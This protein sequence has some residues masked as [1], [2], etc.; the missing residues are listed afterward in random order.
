MTTQELI[1]AVQNGLKFSQMDE[2]DSESFAGAPEGALIAYSDIAVYILKG[3][4]LSVV[5]ED[6]ETQ[7]TL[8]TKFEFVIE[9]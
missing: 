7:Y 9:L 4:M 8:E 1:L 3:N 2:A 5:T 6:L